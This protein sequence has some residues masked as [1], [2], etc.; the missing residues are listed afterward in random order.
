MATYAYKQTMDSDGYGDGGYVEYNISLPF[1]S[2]LGVGDTIKITGRAYW[3]TV[4]I[5][6]IEAC[7]DNY[8]IGYVNKSIAKSTVGTFTITATLTQEVIDLIFED[9]SIEE[10]LFEVFL[11]F[12][13]WNKV[14]CGGGGMYTNGKSAQVYTLLK[15]RTAPILSTVSIS[16]YNNML[17]GGQSYDEFFGGYIQSVSMLSLNAV[18]ATDNNDPK[19]K[20]THQVSIRD[21]NNSIVYETSG[22]SPVLATAF[23]IDLP[24]NMPPGVYTYKWSLIDSAGLS[25][26]DYMGTFTI[27]NYTLPIISIFTLERFSDV[28]DSGGHSHIEADDGEYI[29][30]S[31]SANIASVSSR[32]NWDTTLTVWP[33]DSTEP[34]PVKGQGWIRL[35]DNSTARINTWQLS[36]ADGTAVSYTQNESLLEGLELSAAKSWNVKL[37]IT[38]IVGNSG[39]VENNDIQVAGVVFDLEEN[40]I[41]IGMHSKG[42][43]NEYD[44]ITGDLTTINQAVDI[45]EDWALRVN[46]PTSIRGA[47]SVRSGQFLKVIEVTVVNSKSHAATTAIQYEATANPGTGWTPLCVVGFRADSGYANFYRVFLS[48]TTVNADIFNSRTSAVTLTASVYV[49]CIRTG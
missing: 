32:N 17:P 19:L 11:S 24:T 12:T 34:T 39:T 22:V 26:I 35:P 42:T 31:L 47:L 14:D 10:N 29:W 33:T 36:G 16:D 5:K 9:Q 43:P 48:G 38:D 23:V 13:V 44:P 6:S 18:F 41:G 7:F 49:L 46:G 2:V 15:I 37:T 27:L 20:A 21:G 8:K 40:G 45:A 4:A 30:L 1:K 25:A 3:K 28:I